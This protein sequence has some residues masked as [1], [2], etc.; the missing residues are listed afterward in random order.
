MDDFPDL[1]DF[2]NTYDQYKVLPETREAYQR[3]LGELSE[4]DRKLVED[5]HNFYILSFRNHGGLVMP[6]I[7]RLT[8]T[9][10]SQEIMRLPA[11]MWREN[12]NVCSKGFISRQ[13]TQAD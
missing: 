10:G 7:V 6:I 3:F 11:E 12:A 5:K 1:K 9:D 4:A 2:Y 13:G 8:Y